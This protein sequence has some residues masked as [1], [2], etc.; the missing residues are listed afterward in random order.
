MNTEDMVRML[1][2]NV[3]P[4][5]VHPSARRHAIAS[6]VG[7]A[8]AAAILIPWLGVRP[9]LAADAQL[10]MFWG[11]FGFV[12]LLFAAGLFAATRLS[13]PGAS[14]DW[15]PAGSAA[16]LFAMWSGA[17]LV[18]M[19]AAPGERL[20]LVLG[21]SWISWNGTYFRFAAIEAVV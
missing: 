15:A 21:S 10:P 1:A 3:E 5:P 8:G 17:A 19:Q 2:A 9:Q 4:A 14:L 11:K 20:P 16:P 7:L 13:R 12:A 18:L 6:I